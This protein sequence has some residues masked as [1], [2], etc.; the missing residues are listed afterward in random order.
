[1]FTGSHLTNNFRSCFIALVGAVLA[2]AV[3]EAVANLA[4]TRSPIKS[5]TSDSGGSGT[6][7]KLAKVGGKLI[8]T[9]G[10]RVKAKVKAKVE[11]KLKETLAPKVE[12]ALGT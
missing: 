10:P 2:D 11:V 8:K 6:G 3:L 1:M 12:T 9:A 4:K 7:G 5:K